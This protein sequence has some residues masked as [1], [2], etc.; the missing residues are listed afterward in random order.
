VTAVHQVVVFSR[1]DPGAFN[2]GFTGSTAPPYLGLLE[3]FGLPALLVG[4]AHL[5]CGV[6]AVERGCVRG[7]GSGVLHPLSKLFG[8][9][10]RTLGRDL[11]DNPPHNRNPQYIILPDKLHVHFTTLHEHLHAFTWDAQRLARP[12]TSH[13]LNS[14]TRV[15]ACSQPSISELTRP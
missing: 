7:V 2:V 1:L 12:S 11:S 5:L 13:P 15:Q 3:R 4:A 6:G 10:T 14:S 9:R 8:T